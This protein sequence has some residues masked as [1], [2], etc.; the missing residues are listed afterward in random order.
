MSFS[1]PQHLISS[2]I[3]SRIFFST[4][5]VT[6]NVRIVLLHQSSG[7]S[8]FIR[9]LKSDLIFT[10]WDSIA[11]ESLG[12]WGHQDLKALCCHRKT[13]PTLTTHSSSLPQASRLRPFLGELI[14]AQDHRHRPL[15]HSGALSRT[16][17]LSVH[18]FIYPWGIWA[19]KGAFL[20]LY[21]AAR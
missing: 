12:C 10:T 21:Y 9:H 16:Y 5:R 17:K 4:D 19:K 15:A 2:V 20:A 3:P 8:F 7:D 1:G 11:A 6:H 18:P 13:Q 14:R